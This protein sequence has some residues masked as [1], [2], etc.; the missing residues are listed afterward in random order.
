MNADGSTNSPNNPAPLGSVISTFVNGLAPDPR[1]PGGLPSLYAQAGWSVTKVSQATPFVVEVDL[2]VPASPANFGCPT[3]NP[4]VCVAT[5]QID[6]LTSFLRTSQP[7]STGG[8]S[9]G[10]N[11]YVSK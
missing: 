4:S 7:G 3:T 6:D 2:Q 9:F 8:L 10:G 11:L 1:V 5:F